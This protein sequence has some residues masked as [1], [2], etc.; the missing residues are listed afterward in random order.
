MRLKSIHISQY[1][2]LR[3]FSLYFD[4]DSFIDVFVGKNATG[5]SNLLEA[6]VEIFRHI[7]EYDKSNGRI[8]LG[9]NFTINY[10]IDS[11]E[12]EISWNSGNLI[13][14]GKER[15]TIGNT[16]IPDNLLIYYS[17]HN[18]TVTDLVKRYEEA[19]R[20]RI[21]K[22]YLEESR[23]FIG[24]GPEY[25]ELLLAV[26]LMQDDGNIARRFI[27]N[28]LGITTVGPE[29]KLVLKRPYYAENNSNFDINDLEA[30]R[31][32]QPEGITKEFL[33]RLSNCRSTADSGPIRSEGYFSENDQY[34]LYFSITKIKTEFKGLSGQDLF[35]HFDNLKTL[36]MLEAITMP[37]QLNDDVD[38]DITHF[39]DGQFQSIYIYSIIELFKD[40]NCITLLDEPDAFLHPEWQIEFLNQISEITDS[41]AQSNHV[42]MSSHSAATLC[43]FD[44]QK[45]S[46]LKQDGSKVYCS[47]HSKKEVVNELSNSFIQYSEDESKLLIDNVIRTSAKPILFVEGI[48]DVSILNTA[49]TKLYPDEDIAILVHDAFDRG[50]IKI[51][52]SRGDIFHNY[53]G[54]S[55]FALFD[56]DDAYD[57]WR[58]L[59][60]EYKV[61]DLSMGLCKKVPN[62]KAHVFL[63]PIPDNQLR[64]QVWDE[65]NPI[66]KI[67]PNSHFCIEHI[68]W[69]KPELEN[70]FL[71][72]QRSSLIKF[73]GKQHK[74]KF[75]QEVVPTL[76]ADYFEAFRPMFEFIR[77]NCSV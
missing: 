27:C 35:R 30:D 68:F 66:E 74:V 48:S 15:R 14:D 54:K 69:G 53:P 25:K 7:F 2:N 16:P 59:G 77:T 49:Q 12:T 18:D 20:K 39:S 33:D 67:K 5:K 11:Q 17:G 47:K 3:D 9:F 40:R 51:M 13:I 32:W 43:N 71:T 62:K 8:E 19:F 50:F 24:I 36:G 73:K 70:Y 72:D 23:R 10:E 56:F 55:F 22:A 6:F 21:K 4:N 45:I 44:E 38:A 76:S 28:K 61:T 42:L 34:I 58:K 52:L 60:Q 75:A 64:E 26:L 63:L 37:L 65:S 46:L 57:D 31:Y 41:T 1:K 29:I